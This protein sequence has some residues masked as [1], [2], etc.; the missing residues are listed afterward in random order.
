MKDMIFSLDWDKCEKYNEI[1]LEGFNCTYKITKENIFSGPLK[2]IDFEKINQQEIKIDNNIIILLKHCT[3]I[4][5]NIFCIEGRKV[6]EVLDLLVREKLLFVRM[7]NKKLKLIEN[8]SKECKLDL[9][10]DNNSLKGILKTKDAFFKLNKEDIYFNFSGVGFTFHK[11]NIYFSK[12]T[13]DSKWLNTVIKKG[14]RTNDEQP[15]YKEIDSTNISLKDTIYK[16]FMNM[17]N[18]EIT[19]DIKILN[20]NRVDR[21]IK[22]DSEMLQIL[23]DNGW[24]KK[25]RKFRYVGGD[26]QKSIN[27]LLQN[28]WIVYVDNK[29]LSKLNN[30]GMQLSSGVD[31]FELNIEYEI[32]N[33]L[34]NL[35]DILE[36]IN[37]NRGY[38]ELKTGETIILPKYIKDNMDLFQKDKLKEGKLRLNNYLA[39]RVERDLKNEFKNAS[40]LSRHL[41]PYENINLNLTKEITNRLRNY[42]E[43]GVKW[44]KYLEVNGLGGCLADD[45]GLGKTFQ[46]IS[47]ISDKDILKR[48]SKIIII[49]PKTLL[50]NWKNEL[51]KFNPKLRYYIYHGQDRE[52]QLE[53][54][55]VLVTT[56]G[57][58]RN[59][60]EYLSKFKF[61]ICIFDEAQVIKNANTIGY[62]SVKRINSRM[63]IALTGTPIEN[64]LLELYSMMELLNPGLFGQLNDFKRDYIDT[65]VN[66][67][68]LKEI[69]QCFILRRTKQEVLQELPS[70]IEEILY[71]DMVPEQELLYLVVKEKYR[72]DIKEQ[73]LAKNGHKILEG[74][75]RLRQIC[76]HPEL[77]NSTMNINNSNTSGKFEQLKMIL[78]NAQAARNKILIFSQ[79]TGML[80]IIEKWI[81][82]QGWK[83]SYLDGT[84]NNREKV[85]AQFENVDDNYIFLLSIK[86]AGVGINLTCA[87]YV[88][89]YD[90]WWN[91]A[92]ENQA[93]D[94]AYRIGQNKN[95]IVYRLVTKDTVEEKIMKLS[96]KKQTLFDQ[97]LDGHNII[98]SIDL[99]EL[100]KI[101]DI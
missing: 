23:Y 72:K 101:M 6:E 91:P 49:V 36:L 76:C 59:D 45:M 84:I 24:E 5:K 73:N 64:N 67:E 8:I 21:S 33:N 66:R 56:Y 69:T 38:V 16:L 96:G 58:V 68:K 98:K 80:K 14:F 28:K 40:N 85:I 11:G 26:I 30:R 81:K 99:E 41:V 46:V 20:V 44:L 97:V 25:G 22:I 93:I 13:I 47:F 27:E 50:F 31:W 34:L 71:C 39:F 75:M 17:K 100:S 65:S 94:R 57:V 70:K 1:L 77:V 19:A 2:N 88:V 32:G 92:V 35:I 95:V 52:I 61:D 18:Q 78:Y 89:I 42:Q 90:P 51:M 60:I 74:L 7:K 48:N 62:K 83:Y 9:E 12:S 43:Q 55:D 3:V 87:N 37:K 15:L 53:K 86:A 10:I 82:K 79:Y 54:I 63:K 29:K 4:N